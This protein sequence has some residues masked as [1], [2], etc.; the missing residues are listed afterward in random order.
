MGAALK[1]KPA[2]RG[3]GPLRG[4]QTSGVDSAIDTGL[5]IEAVEPFLIEREAD[6]FLELHRSHRRHSRLEVAVAG[7]QR[8]DLLDAMVLDVVNAGARRAFA[9]DRNILGSDADRNMR[10]ITGGDALAPDG[11]QRQ[12]FTGFV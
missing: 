10:A 6:G 11:V 12:V 2:P 3:R 5:R 9:A 7:A 4:L 8:D 1:R